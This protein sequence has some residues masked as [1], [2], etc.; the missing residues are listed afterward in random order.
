MVKERKST[1]MLIDFFLAF[2]FIFYIDF[3]WK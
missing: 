2:L 1:E 3:I